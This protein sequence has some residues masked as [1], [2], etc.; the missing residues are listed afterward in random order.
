MT[1]HSLFVEYNTTD[2][3]SIIGM[4]S[5]D[6]DWYTEMLYDDMWNEYAYVT[7]EHCIKLIN[8]L[9]EV[10]SF[11]TEAGVDWDIDADCVFAKLI[12]LG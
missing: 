6:V 2:I 1:L 4:L 5:N 12:K 9:E 8:K 3:D 10:K 11:L 7:R